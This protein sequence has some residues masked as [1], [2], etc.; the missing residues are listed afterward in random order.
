MIAQDV[1]PGEIVRIRGERW[2]IG[3]L[4]PFEGTAIVEAHGC[5]AGNRGVHARF[6]A[7]FELL[8][9]LSSA[10]TPRVVRP[11]RWRR[12]A[13]RVLAD[14]A[15]TWRSLR[16]VTRANLTLL[17]FQL[18]PV[19]AL[20]RG[21][22]CRFLIADA[23]G[24]GKT[25][26]AGLM[27]AELLQRQPDARALVVAPS[28]LRDQWR[29]ELAARF[30]LCTEI[31]DAAGVARIAAGLPVGMNPWSAHPLVLTSIDYVKRPEVI[32]SLES[33]L[34]DIVVF[35]EAHGLAGHSDRAAAAA[36]LGRRARVIVMLTATPHSGDPDAFRRMCAAGALAADP[37]LLLFRRTP[38]DV[39]ASGGR[40]TVLLRV[41]PTA[42]EAAMHAALASY[43]ELVWRQRAGE[44]QLGA[45]LAMIVLMRRACSS[46]ASLARS[47]ERRI[48]LL[49]ADAGGAEVQPVLPFPSGAEDDEEPDQILATAGLNDGIVERRLLEQLLRLARAA[50]EHESK[51]AALR[52]FLSRTGERAIV[53]TEYRDTLESI[54]AALHDTGIVLL[55][56][57]L[58]A[59]ERAA[60]L[61]RFD[62]GAVRLLLATDAA[63]EGLN[64][65][66]RCRLVIN[67]ELPWTP[68]RLEQRIGR[69]DRLGQTRR[70]HA[71]HLVAARTGEE[72]V[73]SHL[74]G[75]MREVQAAFGAQERLPKEAHV[76]AAVVAGEALP[77]VASDVSPGSVDFV[78]P[79][80]SADAAAEAKRIRLSR[81]LLDADGDPVMDSRPLLTRLPTRSHRS[82]GV[83]SS[84]TRCC[85]WLFR[86]LFTSNDG[87]V[88]FEGVVALCGAMTTSTRLPSA[89]AVRT[90]LDPSHGVLQHTLARGCQNQRQ[91]IDLELRQPLLTWRNRERALIAALLDHRARL[92]SD[93]LQRGLF[94]RRS[95]R[96][97]AAQAAL[98]SDAVAS[99]SRRLAALSAHERL[100]LS[101][102]ELV[103]GIALG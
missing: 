73:L 30:A 79:N 28:G 88:G 23:V 93:M 54:A 12:A 27:I 58:T 76:A 103:F 15:P 1:R 92:S 59:R 65:H 84:R 50:A 36:A 18:E 101:S 11:R 34:W 63:S 5:D 98:L 56:G 44:C 69:V 49:G 32:R 9:R 96:L 71:L 61:R 33:L 99:A 85:H 48:A 19:L 53:F 60:A 57:G 16:S 91:A 20:L 66:H 102:C 55:H 37:P 64:L 78:V 80:L 43:A 86:S 6:L 72:H 87:R 38:A 77:A 39:G 74:V 2:R 45:R 4:L 22:G 82:A 17:P 68:I 51:P 52:R 21:D 46:A 35:D 26:Q 3:R 62:D 42:N 25:V 83:K 14:A 40:R 97:A 89:A 13:R 100:Q 10:T 31:L 70:V 24:L 29:S 67:L 90:V 94:D 47:V 41:R 7:P 81:A 95:E 75:R 8:E